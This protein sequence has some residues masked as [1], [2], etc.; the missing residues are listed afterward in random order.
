MQQVFNLGQMISED[1]ADDLAL[2]VLKAREVG[3]LN[4][5]TNP[6]YYKDSYGGVTEG[7]LELLNRFTP[8]VR[9]ITGV[10]V[11]PANP[12]SRIYYNESVL[13][14]HVDRPGLDWTIS[15]CLFTNLKHDWPLKVKL[16]DETTVEFP[17]IK[18][19]GNLVKGGTL[20][21]WR[22]PLECDPLDE[23]VVQVFLHWTAPSQG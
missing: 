14:P 3:A 6:E 8:L 13:R 18:C 2:A 7:T 16:E 19:H 17:T 1:E 21:H 20:T 12:F 22:E 5:E 10:E 4:R 15:L 9:M 23:Y 11:E